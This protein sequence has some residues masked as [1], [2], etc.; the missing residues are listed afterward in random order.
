MTEL[1]RQID[2]LDRDGYRD[3]ARLLKEYSSSINLRAEFKYLL[4]FAKSA[5][6]FY[7]A[8]RSQLRSLWTAYCFHADMDVDTRGYDE[9]LRQIW[10]SLPE[11]RE[12]DS[13]EDFATFEKFDDFMCV[14]LV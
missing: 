9:D 5:D 1:E 2:M 4:D 11:N 7:K 13:G 3:A 14:V 10:E 12:E 8:Q 6:F